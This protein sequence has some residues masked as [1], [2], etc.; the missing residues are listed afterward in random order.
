MRLINCFLAFRRFFSSLFSCLFRSYFRSLFKL[1]LYMPTN[2]TDSFLTLAPIFSKS[3]L[4]LENIEL[5]KSLSK[6]I[7][8]SLWTNDELRLRQI[9]DNTRSRPQAQHLVELESNSYLQF[10]VVIVRHLSTSLA[11]PFA[12]FRHTSLH[13]AV[14]FCRHES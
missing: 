6:F 2:S 1:R 10:D 3:S 9:A 7:L 5:L 4:D 14:S 11:P 13:D 12:L 8:K